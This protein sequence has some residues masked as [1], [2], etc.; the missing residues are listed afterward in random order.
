MKS[1]QPGILE[2]TGVLLKP[3]NVG[4][5]IASFVPGVGE[6][7][8]QI[9]G[10]LLECRV[11]SLECEIENV[12]K[13]LELEAEAEP[14]NQRLDNRTYTVAE[15]MRRTVDFAVTYDGGYESR[16]DRGR[17][18]FL[19]VA[20]G[21]RLNDR[22]VI[23]S[24]EAY[25]F[26]VN[27]ANERQGKLIILDGMAWYTFTAD[28]IDPASGLLICHSLKRDEKRWED[29]QTSL[30]EQG[31]A[32]YTEAVI[33]EPKF[34]LTPFLGEEIGFIHTGEAKNVLRGVWDYAKRQFDSSTISHFRNPEDGAIK[35]FA[36]GVLGGRLLSVGSPVFS[37]D[38]DLLGLSSNVE[39][40]EN[41]SGRRIVVR[42]LL[43]HPKFM[44]SK[45]TH[46]N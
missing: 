44:P 23:S 6:A 12:R 11:G 30:K 16:A 13:L 15:F 32:R 46:V 9:E 19:P 34:S 31:F 35:A 43:G 4:K 45:K 38:G 1:N 17:E 41:D 42:C 22:E 5:M 8:N 26:A 28:Q 24:R 20:H 14:T 37:R 33:H 27:V 3:K 18:L 7:I 39:H 2:Q 29:F 25:E 36:S 10:H 21:C 40:Y